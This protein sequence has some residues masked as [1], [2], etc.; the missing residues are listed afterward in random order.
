MMLGID[1]KPSRSTGPTPE[2]ILHGRIAI[3]MIAGAWAIAN[4]FVVVPAAGDRD[5]FQGMAIAM[6]GG[7]IA[8]GIFFIAALTAIMRVV[9]RITTSGVVVFCFVEALVLAMSGAAFG[10]FVL[11]GWLG[12]LLR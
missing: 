2:Q 6:F 12:R 9:A 8:N 10:D 3:L 5:R 7:I 11:A 1:T 4:L